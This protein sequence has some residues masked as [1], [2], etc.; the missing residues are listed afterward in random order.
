MLVCMAMH[1]PQCL[2]ESEDN[3]LDGSF[4]PSLES[5][6]IKLRSNGLAARAFTTEVSCE[7]KTTILS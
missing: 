7:P 4:L 3:I 5:W 2:W 6:G 1:T